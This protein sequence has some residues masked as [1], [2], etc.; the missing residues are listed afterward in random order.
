MQHILETSPLH[1]EYE[2]IEN[3]DEV[4]RI[5]MSIQKE[6]IYNIADGKTLRLVL[7]SR[8]AAEDFLVVGVHPVVIDTTSLQTFLK[9]LAF[10]YNL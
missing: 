9:W 1:L 3:E 7:I 4:T 5:A 2:Q 8:S 6:H 10:H